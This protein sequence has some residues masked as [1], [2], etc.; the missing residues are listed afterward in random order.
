M[1][2]SNSSVDDY[3]KELDFHFNSHCHASI[4][5][6]FIKLAVL[7]S[8]WSLCRMWRYCIMR[9]WC[10]FWGHYCWMVYPISNKLHHWHWAGWQATVRKLLKPLCM[11]TSS[12]SLCILSSKAIASFLPLS[13]TCW[14]ACI[15]SLVCRYHTG[16]FTPQAL[17]KWSWAL[18]GLLAWG[19]TKPSH[20]L[21]VE[22]GIIQS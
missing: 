9:G 17:G 3:G 14:Q 15:S 18:T 1:T 4:S 10:K 2:F 7:S 5:T 12:F 19:T 20:S 8:G 16:G 6:A 11:R 21:W 22:C 13:V